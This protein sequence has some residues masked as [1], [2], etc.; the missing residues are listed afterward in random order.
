MRLQKKEKDKVNNLAVT[1]N[2]SQKLILNNIDTSKF[3]FKGI[4]N[5]MLKSII[6]FTFQ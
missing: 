3:S 5:S 2:K 1:L 4:N 6:K